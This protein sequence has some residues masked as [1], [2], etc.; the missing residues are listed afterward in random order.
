MPPT[1]PQ[2]ATLVQAL[3]TRMPEHAPEIRKSVSLVGHSNTANSIKDEEHG[4]DTV[5]EI[6]PKL[7]TVSHRVKTR[8]SKHGRR[9][10]TDFEHDL[11]LDEFVTITKDAAVPYYGFRIDRESIR[12]PVAS[13]RFAED[14]LARLVSSAFAD[15]E[16]STK[17]AVSRDDTLTAVRRLTVAEAFKVHPRLAL[18]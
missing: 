11:D 2:A 4:S 8:Y 17:A 7:V 1:H 15:R 12:I 14:L 5:A 16:D 18:D 3:E 10:V 6:W 13:K 9:R